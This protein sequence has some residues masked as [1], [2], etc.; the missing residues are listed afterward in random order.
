ME[1]ELLD[2][3]DEKD[4][5]IGKAG[6]REA[7]LKGLRHRTAHIF[8]FREP[9]LKTLL[10]SR[11]SKQ[12]SS[13]S[14]L[15][16]SASGH[17]KAGQS[18]EETALTELHEEIFYGQVF[19]KNLKL[20]AVAKF[21]NDDEMGNYKNKEFAVLF[22]LVCSG[23]FSPNTGEVSEIFW[24]SLDD[25][26]AAAEK[27]PERYTFAFLNDLKEFKKLKGKNLI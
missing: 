3:V 27:N 22:C 23:Q 4:G 1:D 20:V 7:H 15:Q 2:I 5:V 11:R 6:Y 12:I 17:V 24:Q 14:L 18:Y 25:V 8:V 9:E 16:N 21:K 10:I 13:P 26:Y 19:P